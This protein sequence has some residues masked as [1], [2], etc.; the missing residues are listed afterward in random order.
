M[1]DQKWQLRSTPQLT[2]VGLNAQ[3]LA[4]QH[5]AAGGPDCLELDIQL[6]N[7]NQTK[8]SKFCRFDHHIELRSIHCITF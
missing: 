3:Q 4:V 5:N 6:C 1:I 7:K 2:D 8:P